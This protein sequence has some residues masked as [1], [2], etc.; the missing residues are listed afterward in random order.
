MRGGSRRLA[1]WFGAWL[2]AVN[3]VAAPLCQPPVAGLSF[4]P[5]TFPVVCHAGNGVDLGAAGHAPGQAGTDCPLCL[6]HHLLC[7]AV[8]AVA[9]VLATPAAFAVALPDVEP[10]APALRRDAG[11]QQPRAPPTAA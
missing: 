8:P 7:G 11:P 5:Q 4:A 10:V 2:L 9:P 3:L 1:A 6:V